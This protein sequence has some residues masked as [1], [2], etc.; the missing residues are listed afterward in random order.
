MAQVVPVVTVHDHVAGAILKPRGFGDSDAV[1]EIGGGG[2]IVHPVFIGYIG[3]LV[4]RPVAVE[5]VL[6]TL[7]AEGNRLVYICA[8]HNKPAVNVGVSLLV[9]F[10]RCLNSPVLVQLAGRE[11]RGFGLYLRF[12]RCN[13]GRR[14]K[15]KERG[16]Q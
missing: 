6:V 7:V 14:R 2:G 16:K 4:A 8:G 13:A 1:V 9:F 5:I 10:D 3:V 11:A 15:H 12:W